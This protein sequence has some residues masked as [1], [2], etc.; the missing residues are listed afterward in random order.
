MKGKIMRLHSSSDKIKKKR[1]HCY[2]LCL[3]ERT[4]TG[5][6]ALHLAA[7]SDLPE[8]ASVLLSNG[9]DFSAVDE[10]GNNALHVAVREGNVRTARVL[11]TESRLAFR[12]TS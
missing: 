3:Q 4:L 8:I 11:L 9:I 5:Q 1:R 7:E 6:T 12:Y 10:D 2:W